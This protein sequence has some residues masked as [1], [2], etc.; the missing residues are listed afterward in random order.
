MIKRLGFCVLLSLNAVWAFAQVNEWENVKVNDLNKEKPHATFML[1]DNAEKVKKD[2]YR[3]SPFHQSL[4]GLWKFNY[5]E[6]C[7]QDPG[8]L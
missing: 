4:N 8:F 2:E 7:R 1:Y 5:V 3:Q 6:T